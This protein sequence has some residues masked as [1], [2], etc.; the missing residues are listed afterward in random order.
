MFDLGLRSMEGEGEIGDWPAL[1]EEGG[2]GGGAEG[3]VLEG[4]G[5]VGREGEGLLSYAL[6]VEMMGT[7]CSSLHASC[8]EGAAWRCGVAGRLARRAGELGLLSSHCYSLTGSSLKAV[9][10]FCEELRSYS[11]LSSYICLQL[12]KEEELELYG[13]FQPFPRTEGELGSRSEHCAAAYCSLLAL[14][15][16]SMASMKAVLA[17]E[18]REGEKNRVQEFSDNFSPISETLFFFQSTKTV[19]AL[20]TPS[21]NFSEPGFCILSK[22]G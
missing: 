4:W 17:R 6:A 20:D 3:W 5:L 15:R 8:R 7:E 21:C 10:A 1:R 19:S 18:G 12:D 9:T 11:S 13:V 22:G 14:H 2:P 16:L